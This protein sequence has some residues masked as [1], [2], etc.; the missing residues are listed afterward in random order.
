[1]KAYEIMEDILD[2]YLASANTRERAELF[3]DFVHLAFRRDSVD[4]DRYCRFIYW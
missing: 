2:R 3:F 4:R 1:M